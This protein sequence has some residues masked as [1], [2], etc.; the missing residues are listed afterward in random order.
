MN[1]FY[2]NLTFSTD[3]VISGYHE[4]DNGRHYTAN[5][6]KESKMFF[7]AGDHKYDL[8]NITIHTP[9]EHKIGPKR[10]DMELQLHHEDDFGNLASVAI[11]FTAVETMKGDFY[12]TDARN[13]FW[14][15]YVANKGVTRGAYMDLSPYLPKTMSEMHFYEYAGSQTHPPCYEGVHWFVM[16]KAHQVLKS[17]VD[18]LLLQYGSNS[19]PLQAMLERSIGFF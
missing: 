3:S 14:K 11:L 1:T 4:V 10:Y 2:H 12:Q 19:R 17:D 7:R 9:S 5:M 13:D 6:P 8:K 15:G 16:S 18:H